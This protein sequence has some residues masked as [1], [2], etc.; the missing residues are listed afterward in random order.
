MANKWIELESQVYMHV[1]KRTPVVLTRRSEQ[2]PPT[3]PSRGNDGCARSVS[4][5]ELREAKVPV[6]AATTPQVAE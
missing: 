4:E 3:V 6:G 5:R 2:V 1:A